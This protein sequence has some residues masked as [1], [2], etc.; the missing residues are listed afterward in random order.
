MYFWKRNRQQTE[1]GQ[2]PYVP[3]D[4]KKALDQLPTHRNL[5]EDNQ[6]SNPMKKKSKKEKKK[7]SMERDGQWLF[8]NVLNWAYVKDK[9]ENRLSQSLFEVQ[10]I[11]NEL[12]DAGS[13]HNVI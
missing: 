12:D 5:D 8:D 3:Y 4:V 7:P 10:L 13:L 2:S 1:E 9:E 6:G 11:D